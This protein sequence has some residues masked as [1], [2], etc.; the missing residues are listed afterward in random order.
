[1]SIE[2]AL[3]S[4][5]LTRAMLDRQVN[6]EITGAAMKDELLGAVDMI[7]LVLMTVPS[8]G[9]MALT[10]VSLPEE[11]AYPFARMVISRCL[12]VLCDSSVC[13]ELCVSRKD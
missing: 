2:N 10:S 5:L 9:V 1:M 4:S 6:L 12:T 13:S 3:I 8:V 11:S 7:G